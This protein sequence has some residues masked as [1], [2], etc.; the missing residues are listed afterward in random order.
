[1]G[2][3]G[4]HT[5]LEGRLPA[6]AHCLALTELAADGGVVVVDGMA[7]IRKLYTPDLEWLVGGQFQEAWLNVRSFVT[8]FEACGLKLVVFL[9]GGV[10]DAKLGEWQS[11]RQNDL[12]KV[13]RVVEALSRG[14]TPS[15]SSWMPPPNVSKIIGGAFAEVDCHP[16]RMLH[17]HAPV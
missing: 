7:L 4:L 14:D 6:A 11:R 9:D 8:A 12:K 13:D 15:K 10:D 2:V 1:M 16:L 17:V 3:K 5:F